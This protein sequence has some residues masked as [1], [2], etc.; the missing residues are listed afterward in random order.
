MLI[1]LILLSIFFATQTANFWTASNLKV[2]LLQIAIIGIVALPGAMLVL[3][4]YVDLSVGS[5]ATLSV[6]VFGQVVAIEGQSILIGALAALAAGALWGVLNGVLIARLDFSPI[7]VT[8]GGFAAASGL[9]SALT[10][11]QTR[12]GFGDTFNWFG[13]GTLLGLPAPGVFFI[14]AFLITAYVWYVTRLGRHMK[15]VGSDPH[16]ARALGVSVRALPLTL[17]VV[18]GFAAAVGGLFTAAQ[19]DS[20]SLSIGL[21]LEL[22]VLT[23]ILLGGVSF[24]GGRGSLW[25]VLYGLLFIGVLENGLVLV[26]IGPYYA[27]LAVGTV[28]IVAAGADAFYQRLERIPVRTVDPTEA[29]HDTEADDTD[30]KGAV[31]GDA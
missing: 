4:G 14:A 22:S 31:I 20:A 27:D 18:S 5:V 28:L 19:L 10:N 11:E 1:A 21:G 9:A 30:A 2:V 8:L 15:A 25:G 23:A 13:S 24:S 16:S 26:N 17:Y 6:A 12:F 3:C 29:H 7:I